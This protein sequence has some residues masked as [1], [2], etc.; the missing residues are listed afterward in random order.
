MWPTRRVRSHESTRCGPLVATLSLEPHVSLD[1]SAPYSQPPPNFWAVALPFR[2]GSRLLACGPCSRCCHLKSWS[3]LASLPDA[4]TARRL[5]PRRQ[6][7]PP[8]K[9]QPEGSVQAP[10]R[11]LHSVWRPPRRCKPCKPPRRPEKS[12]GKKESCEAP[13][14]PLPRHPWATSTVS[15]P[16][17]QLP[18]GACLAAGWCPLSWFLSRT[19]LGD[20]IQSCYRNR[21]PS[22]QYVRRS[23]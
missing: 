10:R 18:R 13:P 11:T 9:R 17:L 1:G 14:G 20:H 7:M 21:E 23:H 6:G 4:G 8:R 15:P 22:L 12:P 19:S 2:F 16:P 5:A 3:P